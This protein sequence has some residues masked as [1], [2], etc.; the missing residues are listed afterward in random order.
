MKRLMICGCSY[1]AD[2]L[3]PDLVGTGFGH[4]LA[5][6]LGWD[7]QILARQGSSNGG[8]RIQIDEALREKPDFVIVA[9]TFHDRM[10]IPASAAPYQVNAELLEQLRSDPN[11]KHLFNSPLQNHLQQNQG[12]GY[13][14]EYGINNL[15]Y[16]NNPYRI[17][18]ETIFSL[19]ENYD[20]PYR[21]VQIDPDTQA[22]IKQ[23]INFLYDSNWK[24][25]MD[26][27]IIRD[28]VMQ[29]Y[30]AGIQFLFVAN[31]LWTTENV[32]K[33]FPSVIP[34]K[35]FTLDYKLTPAFATNEYPWKG[36]LWAEDPG[37]HGAPESQEYLADVY[38][39]IITE[40]FGITP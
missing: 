10:E 15:N 23:Y 16:R 40:N 4:V 35:Y 13:D 27:W 28:G 12:N 38:Y 14:P 26:Q 20:H 24:K 6:K 5:K 39:K 8:I 31:N 33:D 7:V 19:A 11:N 1:V 17:I 3:Q 2:S 36:K 21:A 18:S 9:P 34:D 37:Y 25:Q 30:F 32:R 29:L 22:A